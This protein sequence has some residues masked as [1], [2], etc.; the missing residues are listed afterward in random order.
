MSK[1]KASK[2]PL[3]GTPEWESMHVQL[4]VMVE[5]KRKETAAF[6]R[7]VADSIDRGCVAGMTGD[8]SPV[9]GN[10]FTNR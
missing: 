3:P 2:G 4:A 7:R 9:I 10:W 1:S 5:G 6:L 8:A